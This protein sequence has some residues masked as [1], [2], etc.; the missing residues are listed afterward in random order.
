[1]EIKTTEKIWLLKQ[2]SS[3]ILPFWRIQTLH[4]LIWFHASSIALYISFILLINFLK[5]LEIVIIV[6]GIYS[7]AI[8]YSFLIHFLYFNRLNLFI[9][10]LD[11]FVNILVNIYL[12]YVS[13]I[14]VYFYQLF[15]LLHLNLINHDLVQ[16]FDSILLIYFVFRY[17]MDC[18]H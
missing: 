12:F 1:M 18:A 11:F 16:N 3:N 15:L 17:L 13:I 2:I 4:F 10:F 8:R 5:P 14:F 9:N 6:I 7:W